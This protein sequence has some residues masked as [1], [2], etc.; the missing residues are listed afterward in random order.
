M[1]F[2]D[3]TENE[4]KII[5]ELYLNTNHSFSKKMELIGNY[6]QKSPRT[7]RYWLQNLGITIKNDDRIN[8]ENRILIIG[9]LH[10]PFIKEGYFE[11]CW[12][13]FHRYDCNQVIFTGDVIDNHYSSFHPTDPDGHSAAKEL[14]LAVDVIK[15]DWY[16]AFPNALV[17][18]GN[19]D[20]ISDRKAFSAGLSNKWIKNIGE[21]LETPG[22]TFDESHYIGDVMFVHGTGMKARNRMITDVTSVVQGHYHSEGYIHH[23]VGINHKMFAMQVGCGIDRTKYAFAYGKEFPKPHINVGI[24]IYG[25]PLLHYMPM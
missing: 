12:D 3:L 14:E 16:K 19:H 10:A 9:D 20:Q 22:W 5:K 25:T 6:I 8:N 21:V 23:S 15:N 4:I 2:N 17:C 13:M 24:I 18:L 1:N 11:F 7:V